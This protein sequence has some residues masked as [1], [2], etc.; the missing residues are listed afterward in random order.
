MT[1]T[2]NLTFAAIVVLLWLAVLVALIPFTTD[3]TIDPQLVETV[4]AQP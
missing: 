1:K 4:G 2:P 3:G